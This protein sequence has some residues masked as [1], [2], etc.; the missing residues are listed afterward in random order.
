MTT[1]TAESFTR[2][3][4]VLHWLSALLILAMF[5][6]GF[7][8]ARTDSDGL[9]ASL[10]AAHAVVGI[11]IAVIAVI[12]FVLARRRP[13]AAPP[14]MPKWNEVLHH[15]VHV[16]A[17]V[18]PVLLAV[19]GVAT[20]AL[21]D[22]MPAVLR[23]GA[24]VPAELVAVPPQAGHRVLAWAYIALLVTHVAGVMRYQF[25]KGDVMGRVGARGFPSRAG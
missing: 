20:L 12:R 18:V 8:M 11:T 1:T 25:S 13:V 5:P 6:M 17:L 16:A 14:G 7:I 24:V 15:S 23:P 3:Q 19:T 4:Q 10:Y 2:T 22:L 21:N 9:R